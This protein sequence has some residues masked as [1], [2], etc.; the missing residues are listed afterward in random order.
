MLEEMVERQ[1]TKLLQVA[2]RIH[3]HV[4]QDDMLQPQ[5]YPEID[6]NPE[7]RYEEGVLHGLETALQAIRTFAASALAQRTERT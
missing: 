3:P 1:K 7:F 2:K 5:D 4:V 6:C